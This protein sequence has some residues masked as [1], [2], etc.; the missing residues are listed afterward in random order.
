MIASGCVCLCVFVY[1]R[2]CLFVFACGRL[3]V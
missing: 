3:Y 1:D 2:V